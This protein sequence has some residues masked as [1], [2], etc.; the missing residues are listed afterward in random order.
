M[1]ERDEELYLDDILTAIDRILTY[2]AQGRE[3][4][5]ADPHTQ[6]AVIRNVEFVG[7]AVRGVSPATRARHPGDPWKQLAGT[8]DR[9]IHGYFAVDLEIVWEIV[10]E[11]LGELREPDDGPCSSSCSLSTPAAYR[12]NPPWAGLHRRSVR[13]APAS[14]ITSSAATST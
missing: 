2:T 5:F 12:C 10:E 3:A 6:D 9:V 7:E 1:P 14:P 11:E 8:R 4:F 13:S